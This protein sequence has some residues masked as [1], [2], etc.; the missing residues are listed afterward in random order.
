MEAFV[1]ARIVHVLG[2]VLWIGGV[3]FV[4]TVIFP[5]VIESG[6]DEASVNLFE[7][8]ENRF[9]WQARIVT[10]VTGLSGLYM[11]Y[12][13]DLWS[14]FF[15]AGYW[16]FYAMVLVW[17]LFTVMLFVLEPL[18]LHRWFIES[19]HRSPQA[20]FRKMNRLHWV[21]LVLSMVTIAGAVAGGHGWL[22]L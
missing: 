3:W 14:L 4:T 1:V 11:L 21:I 20:T 7:R 17:L 9:S 10:L 16:W 13:A 22:W 19:V 2:V 12:A 18:F 15:D 8:I 5:S 6:F